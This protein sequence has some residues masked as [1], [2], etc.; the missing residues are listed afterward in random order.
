MFKLSDLTGLQIFQLTRYAAFIL[1]GICFAKLHLDPS[2]IGEFE[3]FV[4]VSGMVSFFWVSGIINSMLSI[5][6][7]KS[8]EDKKVVLFNTFISLFLFSIVAGILLFTFSDNLLC[9]L[10]KEG[11][12]NITRLVVIYL[13][14]NNPSF[15]IEYILYLNGQKRTIV[16]YGFAAALLSLAAAVVP[17]ILHCPIDYS[18]YGL[19]AVAIL[20]LV[21]AFVLLSRY[22]V[23]R[24][25]LDMTLEHLKLSAPLILSIF[26]S[27][28]AE[29]I[30]GIIVKSKFDNTF[31]AIYRYGA[32][33]LPVL[34]IIA[35]TFSTA[36][37][38][39]I[40]TNRDEGLDT[41]KRRSGKLM[42][43]FF[44]LT[45]VLMVASPFLYPLIF[46]DSFTYS[47]VIFNIY[48]LLII[49][50]VL[51][52]QTILMGIRHSR[53]LLLSSIIEIIINV[54]LSVYL[55]G[56][57]G[58][59][60]VAAGTFIAY[61]IDKIFLAAV[62]HYKFHI[63]PWRYI[64]VK[65]YIVYVTLTFVSFALGYVIMLNR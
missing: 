5:Y 47:A 46:N 23:F 6:P 61:S 55:A 38:S 26:V 22:A 41:L 35:N 57:I 60:G 12:G 51:F 34:L 42:H 64:Q 31:F 62:C 39:V 37:I 56:K 7:K 10:D 18:L 58:L 50:R 32:R 52:P 49:P 14:F 59:P 4:L 16:I 25:D 65:P 28:S 20:R 63:Q 3:T 40:A 36:M 29:Y 11:Q 27:G 24:F 45:I 8:E 54:A 53:Y 21:Y 2:F 48:L 33:E 44:P 43:L 1:I 17:V 30:D 19:I 9:F 15:L 13:L